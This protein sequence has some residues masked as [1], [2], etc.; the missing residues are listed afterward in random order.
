[1][2][3]LMPTNYLATLA[4]ISSMG[5]DQSIIFLEEQVPMFTTLKILTKR[6]SIKTQF[7]S[8][9]DIHSATPR[10]LLFHRTHFKQEAHS[11]LQ[12]GLI[13]PFTALELP[14]PSSGDAT[15][16]AQEQAFSSRMTIP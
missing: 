12:T 2:A 15:E 10:K 4:T 5:A 9:T 3:K 14:A 16:M 11:H 8:A 1:M 13:L 7:I 6:I